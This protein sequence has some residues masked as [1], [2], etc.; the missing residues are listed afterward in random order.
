MKKLLLLG[1][2]AVAMIAGCKDLSLF[3]NGGKDKHD[4]P[5]SLTLK[6]IEGKEYKLVSWQTF[7]TND[8]VLGSQI[9]NVPEGQRYTIR[10]LN[11][12]VDGQI[13]C[14][15]YKG[16]YTELPASHNLTIDPTVITDDVCGSG[17]MD[18]SYLS[19]LKR[20]IRYE[21][22]GNSLKIYWQPEVS[23]PEDTM[24]VMNFVP[25][26]TPDIDNDGSCNII[27]SFAP[28]S[29]IDV[30]PGAPFTGLETPVIENDVLVLNVGY[31][32]GCQKH[33]FSGIIDM[34]SFDMPG[35]PAVGA[36]PLM[37][38]HDDGGDDCEA[39]I[40]EKLR[41]CLGDLR[42]ELYNRY[43]L[44]SSSTNVVLIEVRGANWKYVI[45]FKF[46]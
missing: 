44:S 31:S 35:M 17:S 4:P 30:V 12:Q 41:I 32:G 43:M 8:P 27:P 5:P 36:I 38:L 42:K 25:A 26:D 16:I 3:P 19:S 9:I 23:I 40:T 37:V 1:V 39:A 46:R 6:A 24:W 11:G 45:P 21:I 20:S 22:S 28:F 33:S 10:F 13:D 14:N 7:G 18:K 34:D 29:L 2:L 15:A